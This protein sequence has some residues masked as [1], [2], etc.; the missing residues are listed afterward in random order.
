MNNILRVSWT[1]LTLLIPAITSIG[2]IT[3]NKVREELVFKSPPFAQ[4]HASTIVE[5]TPGKYMVAAFGGTAEGN[6]D[7]C[8]WLSTSENGNWSEPSK[9]ADGIINDTLR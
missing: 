9:M 5:V 1:V 7:V 6:K 8:I 4:C 3:L 2:Q